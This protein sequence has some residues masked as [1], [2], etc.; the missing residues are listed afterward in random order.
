[1]NLIRN[2]LITTSLAVGASVISFGVL[3]QP[4][5]AVNVTFVKEGGN[6]P[7][8]WTNL[9]WTLEGRAGKEP[10]DWEFATKEDDGNPIEQLEWEWQ[11]QEEVP[12]T[13]E[14]D[15]NTVSFNIQDQTIS[16][17]QATPPAT[18]FDGFY[19]WTRTTT[20]DGKVA[21]GTKMFLEVDAV[22]GI[23]IDPVSS[24]AIAP[25]P[26]GQN[27]TKNYFSSDT[28][29]STLS[30][31]ATMSWSDGAPNPNLA[32]ARSLVGLKIE[33]FSTS[34]TPVPE[35]LT[36]LG[37]ATA[38]GFGALFKRQYSKQHKSG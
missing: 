25:E 23:D 28:Q 21:P 33:G 4:A 32:A 37:S 16:Y 17:Y 26:D 6:P 2:K 9:N 12:W 1:M 5:S 11:N 14:W 24:S 7:D 36:L 15:G 35:P 29:I 22:N 38:L 3:S 19:L 34:S 31:I 8:G 30:G 10:G 20:S 13:L 27:I 18:S